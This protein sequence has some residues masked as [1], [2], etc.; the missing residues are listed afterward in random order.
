MTESSGTCPNCGNVIWPG[1]T[2]CPICHQSIPGSNP[3]SATDALISGAE[4]TTA[5]PEPIS[6]PDEFAWLEEIEEPAAQPDPDE[7]PSS[8]PAASGEPQSD[9]NQSITQTQPVR[10]SPP[11]APR[12]AKV[13]GPW[14]VPTEKRM[15]PPP[16]KVS[17]WQW[18]L[19]IAEIVFILTSSAVLVY[20]LMGRPPL[21]FAKPQQQPTQSPLI[22][23]LLPDW[24]A[25]PVLTDH[26]DGEKYIFPRGV[27]RDAL[28]QYT[29]Q[30]KYC[31]DILKPGIGRA[32]KSETL[33]RSQDVYLKFSVV[34]AEQPGSIGATCRDAGDRVVVVKFSPYYKAYSIDRVT[35]TGVEPLSYG[36]QPVE[37][38]APP[39]DGRYD[40]EIYCIESQAGIRI[41]GWWADPAFID[42]KP[43]DRGQAGLYTGALE[44]GTPVDG[45][46]FGACFDDLEIAIP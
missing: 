19:L 17:G 43:E 18:F 30:G 34:P 13:A 23:P 10:I 2:K 42:Q 33:E 12:P 16:P 29:Q 14:Q 8:A 41:N 26:F 21:S 27:T 28:F 38:I 37:N 22:A 11:T 44:T 46:Y 15:P 1:E 45:A 35:R 36:W 39:K 3:S 25:S 32:S 7:P 40:I 6:E 24:T 20:L 4:S 5:L 31:I 9:Q